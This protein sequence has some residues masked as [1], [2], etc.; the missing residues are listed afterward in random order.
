MRVERMRRWRL[1]CCLT[2]TIE[3]KKENRVSRFV[4]IEGMDGKVPGS[5]KTTGWRCFAAEG[6]QKVN[7][8]YRNIR[9]RQAEMSDAGLLCKW[10]NDGK[11]MEHAGFPLGLG[12]TEEEIIRKIETETDETTRRHIIL[13]DNMPVGEMNY[14]R[15]S[16]ET[17]EMG[18]KICETTHQNKGYGTIV[19]HMFLQGLFARLGY[20]KVILDT[21]LQNKR[22]QHVYEKIGFT[23]LRVN[24]NAWMD[25]LGRPQSSVDYE[26]KKEDYICPFCF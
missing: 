15:V 19:L 12:I 4:N 9:I 10:W 21:N 23:K 7:L 16:M 24:E 18:I 11:V 1:C 25:Q 20:E 14:R 6:E 22:A 13:I 5:E 8:S 17:C 26:M 3:F 2:E